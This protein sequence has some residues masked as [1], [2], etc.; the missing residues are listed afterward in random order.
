MEHSVADREPQKC[1]SARAD[2]LLAMPSARR[3]PAPHPRVF[4]FYNR[5]IDAVDTGLRAIVDKNDGSAKVFQPLTKDMKLGTLEQEMD[6]L[7][8]VVGG[9]KRTGLPYEAAA[10]RFVEFIA[11]AYAAERA[12]RVAGET[13]AAQIFAFI[14]LCPV[15]A[16]DVAKGYP[17]KGG[18]S[19]V[20]MVSRE[21]TPVSGVGLDPKVHCTPEMLQMEKPLDALAFARSEMWPMGKEKWPDGWKAVDTKVRSLRPMNCA[22]RGADEITMKA[23]LGGLLGAGQAPQLYEDPVSAPRAQLL[24]AYLQGVSLAD[25]NLRYANLRGA[26]LNGAELYHTDLRRADLRGAD[27]SGANLGTANLDEADLSN[28]NLRGTYLSNANLSETMLDGADL[29]GADLEYATR[30]FVMQK[31]PGW[32]VRD[33]RLRRS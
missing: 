29:E 33:G 9:W 4:E 13:K 15:D 7:R 3:N 32:Q 11:F 21:M 20:L 24:G 10:P 22:W 1:C 26:R 18:V 31:I 27:L 6:L 17:A 23:I 28:A 19:R 25:A 12:C 2:T 30:S 14:R 5:L 8:T 16:S